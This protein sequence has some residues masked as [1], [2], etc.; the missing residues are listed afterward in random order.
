L[1][2]EAV[3]LAS[4]VAAIDLVYIAWSLPGA[5]VGDEWRYLHYANNLLQG[6]YSPRDRVF[7]WNGP[8]YPLV[9][10]PF[11]KAGWQD[12]ARYLNAFWHAGAVLYAWLVLR[13]RVSL[14]WTFV[15]VVVLGVYPPIFEY[16]PL[17][18]T[19]VLCFC[20]MTA[21]IYHS[22]EAAD[23]LFHRLAAGVWLALLVLTKVAFGVVLTAFVVV[24]LAG[25]LKRRS[26]VFES[27]LT[28]GALAFVLCLPYLA[29]TYQLTGRVYYWSSAGANNFY[30]LTSPFAEE[31]GDW[32]HQG[33][34][35]EHALLRAHHKE[36][37]DRTTGLAEDPGLSEQEQ[38]FNLS[39]PEASDIYFQRAVENIRGH[40]LKFL[41]NWCGN[42]V[43]F[44]LD[45]P[46]SVRG[47][48][49]WN[50]Y[51][52]AH[53]PLFA[54]TVFVAASAWCR[55]ARF[56]V[57]WQPLALFGVLTF[58]AYSCVSSMARFSIPLAPL[59][60]LASCCWMASAVSPAPSGT[61]AHVRRA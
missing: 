29:Y 34:V 11:V 51:S 37:F 38:L 59:W 33:W 22:L 32:Y 10:T 9:L 20:L 40:P 52:T 1:V 8:I 21:W 58:G 12:G 46:V 54:W 50:S 31:W 48:P 24:M 27:Y 3:A 60:W 5:I 26:V 13:P 39:T 2:L 35:Y 30:W 47:T 25:R 15:A 43:R 7:L 16:L 55:C 45:V 19:E 41:E 61:P 4:V 42:L 56:P 17:L 57:L 23:S 18:Y 14:H 49:F 44:W 28:Q 53:I 6:Y 36:I